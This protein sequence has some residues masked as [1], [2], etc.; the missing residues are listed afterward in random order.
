NVPT[1]G[2]AIEY[3][4]EKSEPTV[5]CL[6]QSAITSENDAWLMTLDHVGRYY[7]RVLGRKADLQNQ[8]APPGALLDELIGGVYPEKAMLLGQRT[9]DLHRP[10]ASNS[11]DRAFAPEPFNAMA[12]RSVYQSMRASLRRAFI[13]LEK[14]LSDLPAA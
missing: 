7:E 8:T 10:L 4:R 9:A 14:K 2:G 3:R 13:L 1:F 6:L 12:Q 11:D 5:V